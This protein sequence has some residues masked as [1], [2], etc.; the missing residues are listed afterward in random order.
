[1]SYINK[2][3][4]CE[5]FEMPRNKY[6]KGYCDYYRFY[7]YPEES[8]DHYKSMTNVSTCYITTMVCNVLGLP[9]DCEVLSNL[10][11]FRHNI[12]QQNINYIPILMEYDTT[13]PLIAEAIQKEY[14]QSKNKT[15]CQEMYN[16]FLVPTST[17]I[18]NKN[19]Q[20]AIQNYMN[21]VLM[22][23]EYY[24]IE[25]SRLIVPNYDNSIGGHGIIYKKSL[26]R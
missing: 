8:C 23:K 4:D 10:R 26:N 17:M 25:N 14:N 21:M 6:E 11:S 16:K 5:Y 7:C 13:G 2:C 22:L 20:Q 1:M 24:C 15:I 3:G 12:L 19:Y 18:I 9:D